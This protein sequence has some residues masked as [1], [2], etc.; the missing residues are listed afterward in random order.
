MKCALIIGHAALFLCAVRPSSLLSVFHLH[1]SLLILCVFVPPVI[2]L[3]AEYGRPEYIGNYN[4]Q[5][6][7]HGIQEAINLKTTRFESLPR[8]LVI[9]LI[10]FRKDGDGT[11]HKLDDAIS[12]PERLSMDRY[13]IPNNT[14]AA[15]TRYSLHSVLVH[16]GSSLSNGHYV[17]F[18]RLPTDVD[19]GEHHWVKCDDATVTAVNNAKALWTEDDIRQNVYMLVYMR[20][21]HPAQQPDDAPLWHVQETHVQQSS[22]QLEERAREHVTQHHLWAQQHQQQL[23]QHAL[24]HYHHQ[25]LHDLAPQQHS[26]AQLLGTLW[27]AEHERAILAAEHERAILQRLPKATSDCH[28]WP[29]STVPVLHVAISQV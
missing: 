27:A 19:D 23:H 11:F 16:Y 25:H 5:H 24:Q 2:S 26:W 28:S 10:R 4:A 8:V 17:V 21:S 14:P 13:M 9:Q 1:V 18:N 22:S 7:G 15:P 12:F 29:V 6:A 3:S 20:D